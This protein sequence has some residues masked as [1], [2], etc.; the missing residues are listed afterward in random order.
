MKD[1]NG[2]TNAAMRMVT[3][4]THSG[5]TFC[6]RAKEFLSQQGIWFT[7]RDLMV[8]YRAIAELEAFGHDHACRGHRG[9]GSGRI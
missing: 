9:G 7:E 4:Y 6:D 1:T 8:D 2:R 5:R 3:V